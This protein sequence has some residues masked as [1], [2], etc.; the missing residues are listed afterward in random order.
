MAKYFTNIKHNCDCRGTNGTINPVSVVN[1]FNSIDEI[2]NSGVG[3]FCVLTITDGDGLGA[4]E[5]SYCKVVNPGKFSREVVIVSSNNNDFVDFSNSL[6]TVEAASDFVGN[7]KTSN[8]SFSGIST[9]LPNTKQ[10]LS[11]T[12]NGNND[13]GFSFTTDTITAPDYANKIMI[14]YYFAYELLTGENVPIIIQASASAGSIAR[15]NTQTTNPTPENKKGFSSGEFIVV[16]DYLVPE[17]ISLLEDVPA[18]S[19]DINNQGNSELNIL[20]ARV[21][22]EVMG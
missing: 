7:P 11:G 18:L 17:P 8:F 10:K 19:F 20:A 5:Q 22:C 16:S 21:N 3:T 13:A 4:W 14:N 1:G 2:I 6:H 15:R 9:V 12:L